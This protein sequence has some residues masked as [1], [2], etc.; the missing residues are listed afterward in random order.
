MQRL[1]P[2]LRCVG[3]LLLNRI[4]SLAAAVVD[5]ACLVCIAPSGAE[6]LFVQYAVAN[7]AAERTAQQPTFVAGARG[8]YSLSCLQ[9]TLNSRL[10]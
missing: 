7:P 8:G 9:C 3:T 6:S 10:L 5:T 4:A 2:L 1:Q